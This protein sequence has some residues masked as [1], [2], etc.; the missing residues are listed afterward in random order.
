M[1]KNKWP[2]QSNQCQ[3]IHKELENDGGKRVAWSKRTTLEHTA[4]QIHY[5]RSRSNNLLS[6]SRWQQKLLLIQRSYVANLNCGRLIRQ[7]FFWIKK[8]TFP[9]SLPFCTCLSSLYLRAASTIILV[10]LNS[11]YKLSNCLAQLSAL[12]PILFPAASYMQ[13]F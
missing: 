11:L 4:F 5:K 12:S 13:F 7:L 8:H 10:T 3:W 6:E 1:Q 9:L 2:Q